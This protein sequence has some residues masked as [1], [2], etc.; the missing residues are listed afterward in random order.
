MRS[1]LDLDAEATPQDPKR[2]VQ[3]KADL[4]ELLGPDLVDQL[5]HLPSQER[6]VLGRHDLADVMA[7]ERK[8]IDESSD[9]FRYSVRTARSRVAVDMFKRSAFRDPRNTGSPPEP[10]RVVHEVID[11]LAAADDKLGEFLSSLT[12]GSRAELVAEALAVAFPLEEAWPDGLQVRRLSAPQSHRVRVTPGLTLSGGP[13]LRFGRTW[14]DG[15][16]LFSSAV[17]LDIRSGDPYEEEERANRWY[18]GLLELLVTGV[19]PARVVSWY[20]RSQDVFADVISDPVVESSLRRIADGVARIVEMRY[21]QRG[22]RVVPGW[23]CRFC[24]SANDCVPGTAWLT[25]DPLA[26]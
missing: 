18:L 15:Q 23:R 1:A 13:S 5:R 11:D 10:L 21:Q 9:P 19:A 4:L 16:A 2:K 8:F 24:E 14:S 6:L 20:P 3:C 26:G 12:E 22:P 7:C 25:R 17:L